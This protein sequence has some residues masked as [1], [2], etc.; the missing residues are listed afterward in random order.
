MFAYLGKWIPFRR[1][2]HCSLKVSTDEKFTHVEELKELQ[3]EWKSL[4]VKTTM[5]RENKDYVVLY[6]NLAFVQK[7]FP[8]DTLVSC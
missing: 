6:A 8:Q 4:K 1:L 3:E 5:I 2:S 7:Y